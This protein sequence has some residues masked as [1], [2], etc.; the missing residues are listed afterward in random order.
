AEAVP[1]LQPEARLLVGETELLRRRPDARDLI[2]RGAGMHEVDRFVE[3]LAALLVRI[4]LRTR[5]AAHIER[6]VIARPVAHERVD[7]V[8]EGLIAGPKETVRKDVGVRVAAV[9]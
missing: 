1:E 4:D 3:P 8:E 2:R 6:P 7:D 9:A 5:H